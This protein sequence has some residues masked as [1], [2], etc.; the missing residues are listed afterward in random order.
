MPKITLSETAILLGQYF[1][2]SQKDGYWVFYR[3]HEILRWFRSHQPSPPAPKDPKW[4]ITNEKLAAAL[5]ELI[6][7]NIIYLNILTYSN[8][9]YKK[10]T[11]V[12][13]NRRITKWDQLTRKQWCQEKANQRH[14]GGI[15][16]IRIRKEQDREWNKFHNSLIPELQEKAIELHRKQQSLVALERRYGKSDEDVKKQWILLKQEWST[17]IYYSNHPAEYTNLFQ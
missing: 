1:H 4:E 2:K 6:A 15:K 14:G 5:K 11:Y 13:C 9:Q 16:K 3:R 12:H 8:I 7:H 17:L 10:G